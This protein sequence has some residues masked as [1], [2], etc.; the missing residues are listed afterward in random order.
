M[1]AFQEK[2]VLVLIQYLAIALIVAFVGY[3]LKK[4]LEKHKARLA[5]GDVIVKKKIDAISNCWSS[6][7]QWEAT[8][9]DF[10]CCDDELKSAFSGN[11]HGYIAAVPSLSY[12]EKRSKNQSV[13]ARHNVE[14]SRFWL[15]EEI[16]SKFRE[17]NNSL[18][19]YL[20][21]YVADDKSKL[22]S[23]KQRIENAKSDAT[24]TLEAI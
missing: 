4:S 16:Y 2:I 18:M 13:T 12:L 10:V 3:F 24:K 23:I 5:L 7:Y 9:F 8:I 11:P 6:M 19:D 21:A 1:T 22:V 17:Y 14:S 15:G 20:T